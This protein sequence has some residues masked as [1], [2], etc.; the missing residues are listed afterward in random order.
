MLPLEKGDAV[1][2]A[3]QVDPEEG[4]HA[5]GHSTDVPL[6][7]GCA[8]GAVLAPGH[9]AQQLATDRQEGTRV[10][11]ADYTTRTHTPADKAPTVTNVVCKCQVC[12][13]EWQHWGQNNKGCGFCG[14]PANAITKIS[15]APG[16]GGMLVK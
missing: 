14:A 16:Y 1:P 9:R 3:R 5:L 15:E 8:S 10:M 12:G 2:T 11:M 7:R 4:R 6:H 13:S